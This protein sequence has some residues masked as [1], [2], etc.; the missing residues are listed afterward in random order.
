MPAVQRGDR[1]Y[2]V[3]D[4]ETVLDALLRNGVD[5]AN[6]CR[7]GHCRSC[8]LRAED[9][10]TDAQRGLKE[11]MRER[12]YFLACLAKPTRDLVL[13][14]GEESLQTTAELVSRHELAP[15]VYRLVLAPASPLEFVPGQFL[16]VARDDGL[17][18][19]YS[20]ASLPRQGWIE[21]HVRRVEDGRMSRWLTDDLE[22]GGGVT[23]RG[24][25]GDC[26]YVSGR[27]EQ[28]LLLA[29]V[30]TGLSPLWGIVRD[31]LEQGHAGQ[32][33]LWQ[34]AR[35]IER[36]YYRDELR[37]LEDRWP[38]F[39]YRECALEGEGDGGGKDGVLRG[40]LTELVID[41][42][43]VAAE[44]RAFLCGAP[45]FVYDLKR[46]LFMA[47]VSMAEI[48]ADPFVPSADART[49]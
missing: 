12:G 28:P 47:G 20:I 40:S 44:T 3:G 6:S 26:F 49:G 45:A 33:T 42:L 24:P 13:L 25:F 38:N 18:R 1:A 2:E 4:G 19:S 8:L 39:A 46:R 36:L 21:L 23:L 15:D 9:P 14:D 37:E 5:V 35:S 30:G 17:T 22:E 34:G 31:A 41:G 11:T 7:A 16:S 32:V 43:D 48:H 29:G 27:S 10:P